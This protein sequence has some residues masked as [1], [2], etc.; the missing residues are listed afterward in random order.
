MSYV[1][2]KKG[3]ERRCYWC[4]ENDKA[5]LTKDHLP[6]DC[7]FP[8]QDRIGLQLI[9]API[10]NRCKVIHH[11]S[12]DDNNFLRHMHFWASLGSSSRDT[13]QKLQELIGYSSLAE[14]RGIVQ[15]E[16]LDVELSSGQV[17][18]YPILKGGSGSIA[19]VLDSI[20]RAFYYRMRGEIIPENVSHSFV[21]KP[22]KSFTPPMNLLQGMRPCVVKNH[23]FEF[24]P[25]LFQEEE[26]RYLSWEFKFYSL[27]PLPIYYYYDL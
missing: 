8:K 22:Q 16:Y 25:V 6:P 26:F 4:Y 5:K 27:P 15:A 12:D 17:V 19:R 13:H 23:V 9:T 20:A 24:S 18:R 3:I 14:D 7:I 1:F 21:F 2:F 11:T 10:C